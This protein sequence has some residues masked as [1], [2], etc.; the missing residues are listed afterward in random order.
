MLISTAWG[1]ALITTEIMNWFVSRAIHI[2][3]D[4]YFLNFIVA[5]IYISN[6]NNTFYF[7]FLRTAILTR[8]TLWYILQWLVKIPAIE[9]KQK[10]I[11]GLFIWGELARLGGVADLSEMI[12]IPR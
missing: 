11:K 5:Y 6:K 9:Q 8:F 2:F 7:Q 1:T 10:Q 3:S 4:S 12:F